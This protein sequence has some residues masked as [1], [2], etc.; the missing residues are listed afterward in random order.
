MLSIK[1]ELLD[2]PPPPPAAT[3]LPP[4]THRISLSGYRNI[5]AKSFLKTM[6]MDLCV[7]RVVLSLLENRR[8]LWIRVHKSPKADWEVLG[9]EVFERTGK[10]VSV[11]QLQRIFLTARD[12]LRRNLQLYIIQRKMDKLTLD[13]EL[14]KWELYPHFIYYRQYLGQFEAHLRGEEWTGEL[15]DDDIICD[16][17]MQVEVSTRVFNNPAQDEVPIV[18]NYEGYG[19]S[20]ASMAEA[21]GCEHAQMDTSRGYE[22]SRQQKAAI[23]GYE[24]PQMAT[25]RGYEQQRMQREATGG[26]EQPQVAAAFSSNFASA[27]TSRSRKRPHSSIKQEDSVSYTKITEDLLQKKPHKHRFIR[28]ALFKTIMALDDDEVEYTELADLF[29]DIAEQS[30][31]VRR[32]RLQRQQQRGRG[33]QRQVEERH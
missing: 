4:I 26:C 3:P 28:Q 11:K 27:S 33:E 7:R 17:I 15:Y 13:A 22:Q 14:A 25:P 10:A 23:G 30:N 19:G 8:A 18:E 16:G 31:V 2:A 9:V 5:H 24:Q 21:G 29:G 32:L 1:Q 20:V 6:T 12:W